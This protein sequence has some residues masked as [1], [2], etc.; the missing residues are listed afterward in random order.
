MPAT[1][2]AL[3]PESEEQRLEAQIV[4]G[5]LSDDTRKALL[6]QFNQQ[7]QSNQ[8]AAGN[9]PS[10]PAQRD[11]QRDRLMMTIA[12]TP[13]PSPAPANQNAQKQAANNLEKQDQLL[14]GL[15]LGS[16]EFQRR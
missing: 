10:Q 2:A 12:Q 3:T 7:A 13:A 4:A 8:Q 14:A 5:G 9:A 1:P 11:R 6:D 16:P 15:L